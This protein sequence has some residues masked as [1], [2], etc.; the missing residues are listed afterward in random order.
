MM[1]D[2][3]KID[4]TTTVFLCQG[5]NFDLSRSLLRDGVLEGSRANKSRA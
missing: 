1:Q 4:E 5:L 2:A 3:R